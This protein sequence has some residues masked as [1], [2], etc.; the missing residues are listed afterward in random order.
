VPATEPFARSRFQEL[1]DDDRLTKPSFE[2]L[3][4]GVRITP[5][6][7]TNPPGTVRDFEFEPVN[8]APLDVPAPQ[9]S[10]PITFPVGHL[11]WHVASG[12]AAISPLRQHVRL[13]A[14][15]TDQRVGLATTP[16]LVVVDGGSLMTAVV[17][18]AEEAAAPALAAQRAGAGMLVLEAHEVAM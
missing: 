11:G 17:L 7:Q 18:S 8:L 3:P 15:A 4:A 16:P 12:P 6:G 2:R 10:D 14:L 1:N 13:G 9:G 5:V